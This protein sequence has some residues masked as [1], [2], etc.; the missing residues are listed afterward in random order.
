LGGD[1]GPIWEGISDRFGRGYRTDLG[2]D[3]GGFGRGYR[4]DLGGDIGPIWEGISDRFGRGYRTLGRVS[5]V[6][7]GGVK[8]ENGP[9]GGSGGEKC[10][11]LSSFENLTCFSKGKIGFLRVFGFW[12]VK[13]GFGGGV[14]QAGKGVSKGK[15]PGKGGFQGENRGK[16]G[17]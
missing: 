2:G 8:R 17:F 3:I 12:G 4:T 13:P 11:T 6:A 15:Q 1:I 16:T 7:G 5:G 10:C 14:K 9:K